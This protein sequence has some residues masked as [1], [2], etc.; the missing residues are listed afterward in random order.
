MT[1]WEVEKVREFLEDNY[2]KLS[3]WR[4]ESIDRDIKELC[5]IL[6]DES[7]QEPESY[8]QVGDVVET[9]DNKVGKIVGE[10]SE[11]CC[12][13]IRYNMMARN[14]WEH[15]DKK[16]HDLKLIYREPNFKVKGG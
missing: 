5:E 12:W 8:F 6:L 16:T 9:K 4:K 11:G 1:K 3:G 7:P 10:C 14:E 13:R 15:Y 2:N